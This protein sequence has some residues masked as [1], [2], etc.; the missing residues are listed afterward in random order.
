MIR[1]TISVQVRL[2]RGDRPD[3]DA[4]WRQIWEYADALKLRER[5]SYKDTFY[6]LLCRGLAAAQNEKEQTHE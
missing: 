4:H 3:I 2:L 5:V 6:D 1:P